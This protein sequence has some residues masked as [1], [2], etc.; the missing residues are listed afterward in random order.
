MTCSVAGDAVFFDFAIPN[1]NSSSLFSKR[2]IFTLLDFDPF[3]LSSLQFLCILLQIDLGLPQGELKLLR[4]AL[5][6]SFRQF[7][8]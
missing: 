3:R 8:F 1:K 6:V 7:K 4:S 5:M 2:L